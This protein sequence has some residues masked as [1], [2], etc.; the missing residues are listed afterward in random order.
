VVRV[1]ARSTPPRP[2]ASAATARASRSIAATSAAGE[3]AA[4]ARPHERDHA[5]TETSSMT[6]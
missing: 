5:A 4:T 3:N 6:S 2:P 1:D